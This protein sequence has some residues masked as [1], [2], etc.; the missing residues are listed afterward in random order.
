MVCGGVGES[1]DRENSNTSL[2]GVLQQGVLGIVF[3]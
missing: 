3:S 2:R 1:Y